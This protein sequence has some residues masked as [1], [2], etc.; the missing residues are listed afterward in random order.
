MFYNKFKKNYI[1]CIL[2]ILVY[3]IQSKLLKSGRN[4]L[5]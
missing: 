5:K 4:R 1:V 2:D 3:F